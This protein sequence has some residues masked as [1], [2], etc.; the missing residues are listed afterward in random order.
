MIFTQLTFSIEF[1]FHIESLMLTPPPS[2]MDQA[3]RV[4]VISEIRTA[5][6][7]LN[8][9][10]HS[11]LSPLDTRFPCL[12]IQTVDYEVPKAPGI[13]GVRDRMCTGKA[14]Q[15]IR[16]KETTFKMMTV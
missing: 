9:G 10:H 7:H 11:S 3:G 2:P 16:L 1:S 12:K 14:L 4:K 15:Q 6:V 5:G 13:R 8:G